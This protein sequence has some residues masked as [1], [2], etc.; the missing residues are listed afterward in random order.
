MSK[1]DNEAPKTLKIIIQNGETGETMFS[2]ISTNK[3]FKTGSKGYNCSGKMTN[4]KS[5][6]RYQISCNVILIGS[7]P[8]E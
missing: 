3:E 4:P 2:E 1:S 5:G 8:K 6:E 7:K